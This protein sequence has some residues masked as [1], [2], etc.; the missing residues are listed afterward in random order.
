M[1]GSGILNPPL[2]HYAKRVP[3]VRHAI[4]SR[5]QRLLHY[6]GRA[7]VSPDETKLAVT[8]LFDG[9]DLYSLTNQSRLNSVSV[10]MKE[11][12][13][14][15]VAFMSDNAIVF[16][17]GSGLAYVAEGSPPVVKHTLRHGDMSRFSPCAR[18]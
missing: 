13:P 7:A 9:V 10:D 2:A 14:V 12:V 1:L 16:G 5:C 11:N 18:F 4:M 3:N 17:G 6:R 8:N 15:A